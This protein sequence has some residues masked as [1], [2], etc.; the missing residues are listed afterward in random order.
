MPKKQGKKGNTLTFLRKKARE[1]NADCKIK[2]KGASGQQLVVEL[3]KRGPKGKKYADYKER[4]PG[5]PRKPRRTKVKS[6]T[7]LLDEYDDGE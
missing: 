4:A 2:V 3:G 1:R 6:V 7:S 5:K